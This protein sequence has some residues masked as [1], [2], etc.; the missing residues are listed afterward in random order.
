MLKIENLTKSYND[1][2]VFD[3]FNLEISENKTTAIMGVSGIGK[4]TL[5][6]VLADLTEYEGNIV[7]PTPISYVFQTPRLLE[8]LTVF[9]NL[10]Y[11]LKNTDLSEEEYKKDIQKFL[12]LADLQDKTHSLASELSGGQKQRVS[13]IRAFLYPSKLLLMDEPFNSLDVALKMRIIDL[14]RN[15]L[16]EKPRTV[17]FVSH[18]VDEALWVSDEIIVLGNNCVKSRIDL[19]GEKNKGDLSK[20]IF[21]EARKQIYNSLIK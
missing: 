6:N 21:V 12:L 3:N 9:N 8:H 16:S 10:R 5:L 2:K 7:K 17:V 19:S 1:L 4:S 13:L 14:Y 11:V 18:D 15:L 20:P